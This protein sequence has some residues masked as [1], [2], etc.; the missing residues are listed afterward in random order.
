MSISLNMFVCLLDGDKVFSV[1]FSLAVLGGKYPKFSL[2]M[3]L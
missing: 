3:F 1:M 2:F